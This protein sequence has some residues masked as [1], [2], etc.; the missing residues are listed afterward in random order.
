MTMTEVGLDVGGKV[1][2]LSQLEAELGAAGITVYGLTVEGPPNQPV[3]TEPDV[4]LPAGSRLYTYDADANP[5]DL[6]TG[7]QA[8]VDA[9]IAMR[10]KTDAEYAT[11]FQDANTTAAR[12]QEIRDIT[13]GLLP[14]EQVPITQEEWDKSRTTTVTA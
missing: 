5:T 14:R 2:N 7:S 4:H 12:K 10:D 13:G 1:L 11:E 3:T 8:V 6:P 9:H